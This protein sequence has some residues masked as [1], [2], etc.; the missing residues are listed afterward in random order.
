MPFAQQPFHRRVFLGTT[1]PVLSILTFGQ[2]VV[3]T[4]LLYGDG[5]GGHNAI[6]NSSLTLYFVMDY[7]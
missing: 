6:I 1:E 3:L 5:I 7:A 2:F 4:S